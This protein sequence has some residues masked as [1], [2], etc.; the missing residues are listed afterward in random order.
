MIRGIKIFSFLAII[1]AWVLGGSAQN[2]LINEL[3]SVNTVFLD[4]F[5]K[6]S[7]WIELYNSSNSIQD[8]SGMRISDRPDLENAWEIGDM[9]MEPKS[10]LIIFASGRNISK[11]ITYQTIIERG[12]TWKYR[13]PSQNLGE[14]WRKT[15]YN[16][17]SWSNGASGFGYGDGDDNTYLSNGLKSIFIRK[18]F[19]VSDTA[20]IL[21]MVLHV[22]YDDAFIAYIN[23]HE[24]ARS[25]IGSPGQEAGYN[26]TPFTD[27]EALIYGGGYPDE[28]RLNDIGSFLQEGEN[29]LCI[30]GY[31]ISTSSSDFSL[32]PFL[33]VGTANGSDHSVPEI[34]PLTGNQ[35]HTDFKLSST[36]ENL[37]LFN[38][39]GTFSDSIAF[40][41]LLPDISFGRKTGTSADWVVFNEP[42]PGNPNSGT[43]YLGINPDTI[44]FS[45][46][47]GIYGS[48]FSLQLSGSNN[49]RYTKDNSVPKETSAKYQYPISISSN[50]MIRA[51][52]FED[53]L[54]SKVSSQNYLVNSTH[55]IPVVSLYTEEKYLWDN[56]IGM[57]TYGYNYDNNFPFFGANFWEDFEYPFHFSYFSPNGEVA[58]ESNVSAKIFG[59]YS[60]GFAQK[61]FSLFARATDNV[62]SFKYPFF[63]TRPYSEFEALILR[64][65]GNDWDRAFIRD[66]VMTGLVK[67][68]EVDIQAYQPVAAYLNGDYWGLYNMREKINEH[69][70]ASLHNI[71]P[72]DVD[73]IELNGEIKVGSNTEYLQLRNYFSSHNLSNQTNY[74]YVISQLDET[75]F[76][77]YQMANIYYDNTDWPGNNIR[78]W[79][80][81]DTKWRWIMYDTDFGLDL[82]DANGHYHNTLAFATTTNGSNW[83]NP[84]WSTLFLRRMLENDGFKLKFVNYLADAMNTIFLPDYAASF[85]EATANNISAEIVAHRNRWEHYSNWNNEIKTMKNF[86]NI[87]PGVVRGFI[88]ERFD[89]PATQRIYTQVNNTEMGIIQL[90]SLRITTS[91]WSGIYFQNNPITLT[92]VPKPGHVFD[93]WSGDRNDDTPTITINLTKNTSVKANFSKIEGLEQ[94]VVINEINYNSNQNQNTADWIELHNFSDSEVNISGWTLK[95]MDDQHSF[96]L[97]EN[98]VILP[99][100]YHILCRNK[101]DF[102]YFNPFITFVTGN[103]DFGLGSDEDEVRLYNESGELMD[104]VHYLSIAPWPLNAN[105]NGPTLELLSP[106][107]DNSLEGSW[108]AFPGTGTPGATNHFLSD[109][110]DKGNRDG[111]EVF[112]NPA[113]DRITVRCLKTDQ[114]ISSI[115]IYDLSGRRL[116]AKQLNKTKDLSIDLSEL[117]PG[118]YYLF[119]MPNKGPL[120]GKLI[121]KL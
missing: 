40:P 79:K 4:D 11:T 101:T 114:L 67:E 2:V 81:K 3:V 106:E 8:L 32:I 54:I 103:F 48:S 71:N 78:C 1:F 38:A 46:P 104:S 80:T 26:A 93:H 52:I 109:T 60:R 92:A 102:S 77:Q 96:V 15:D 107:L 82:F 9:K 110:E 98:T 25:N 16:D 100:G 23:N 87:R 6:S 66:A 17:S 59:G 47:S 31:N 51:R 44:V 55:T 56:N 22:D 35:L 33:T 118:H 10:Y 105:G 50:T 74:N 73:L 28:F 19:T 69:Y 99:R 68:T 85:I 64:N 37:Y 121:E 21:E 90:N 20:D 84:P 113:G 58:F 27:H 41:A 18:K 97:P 29:V 70:L 49:I 94:P 86:F 5:G 62:K 61:S 91:Y 83:P 108:R 111:F 112:P 43:Y 76:I 14:S 89:L 24:I 7:D 119:V 65:A 57:Y 39:D 45:H 13:V 63:Q 72:D 120:M 12:D 42:S 30:Q 116:L 34:L 95:D 115:Q 88:K 36:G 75:N 53:D 117:N